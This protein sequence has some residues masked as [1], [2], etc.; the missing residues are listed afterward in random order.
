[1]A[2]RSQN[3]SQ[4]DDPFD[5]H[6]LPP[7]YREEYRQAIDALVEEDLEGYYEFLQ[8][9]DVVDFLCQPEV[10]HI[11]S[12][13]QVPIQTTQP[14]LAYLEAEADGSSDTYWPVHSDLDAPA[15]ELGWPPQH[16]CFGPTE[17]TMLVNPSDRNMPSIKEQARRLICS[18]QQVIAVVMDM[19]TDVDLFADL[20][21]A[22]MRNVA[23]YILLDEQNA[24]Y[25]T[26]MV[27]NCKVNLERIH[28]MRV[29]TVS[30]TTYLCRTGKSFKGQMMDRFLLVDCKAVLSGN[31]SFMWSFE[32]I[33]RCVAHLFLGELVTTFDEEF[34]ILYAQSQAL[35]I[36]NALVPLLEESCY[37]K[38]RTPSFRN[39]IGYQ[40]M[41]SSS[42]AGYLGHP[43]GDRIDKDYNMLPFRRV[44]P[45][46]CPVEPA[47]MYNNRHSSK[48]IRMEQSFMEQGRSMMTS[49]KMERA[50]KRHSYAEGS[51]D[52]YASSQQLMKN[53]VMNNLEEMEALSTYSYK[54]QHNYQGV[55]PGSGHAI[56]EKIKHHGYSWT[57]HQYFD[58]G[59]PLEQ[60]PPGSY[61][62]I[63]DC[64]SSSSSKDIIHDSENVMTS[65]ERDYSDVNPKRMSLG[66]PYICQT[67]PTQLHPPDQRP[68]FTESCLDRQPQDPGMKQGLRRWRINSYLSAFEDAT[69]EALPVP[70]GPDAFE[71]PS[72]SE[73]KLYSP[74][75][76]ATRFNTEDFSRITTFKQD[77][78]PHDGKPKPPEMQKDLSGDQTSVATD[79]KVTPTASES[80]TTTESDKAEE[81]ELREPR[82]ISITKQESFRSRVSPMFQR[83]SRLRSSLI[84][85]S[86]NL[87]QNSSLVTKFTSGLDHKENRDEEENDPLKPS[88]AVAQILEKRRCTIR[89]PFDWR[90]HKRPAV[91]EIKESKESTE[92]SKESTE[93]STTDK[94]PKESVHGKEQTKLAEP[95]KIAPEK[96]PMITAP[97]EPFLSTTPFLNMNDPE[98]RLLYFKELAAKRK[99]SKM[100]MDSIVRGPD[101]SENTPDTNLKTPGISA[102]LTDSN[103]KLTGTSIVGKESAA[104]NPIKTAINRPS[105]SIAPAEPVSNKPEVPT[106]PELLNQTP[107][108]KKK[109]SESD[110]EGQDSQ[111]SA[112]VPKT[113]K[114]EPKK[115]VLKPHKGSHSHVSCD[116]ELHSDATD[117][118]KQ[119]IKKA[120]NHCASSMTLSEQ[121]KSLQ[122]NPCLT[123]TDS[124]VEGKQ[125]AKAMEFVKKHPQKLQGLLGI[126]GDMEVVALVAADK[127]GAPTISSVP[128]VSEKESCTVSQ[129]HTEA[130]Q[131]IQSVTKNSKEE[132][133][134]QRPLSSPALKA[135]QSRYQTNVIYS[136]NLRDDTKVM[137]EQISASSQNRMELAKKASVGSTDEAK[138]GEA[139]GSVHMEDTPSLP[140]H[141]R[142]RIMHAQ[143]N[144]QERENLLK[145]IENMRKENKVYSRFE[146]GS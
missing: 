41:E 50:H 39:P 134:D 49:R 61:S 102:I 18:A 131:A 100:A 8:S 13:V 10:E 98:I 33:H 60:E 32:K 88:T 110:R 101:L 1:M 14:E 117:T 3:S 78:I 30:G 47:E 79:S 25:F 126:K 31:Y 11:K 56:N 145:K 103:L 12:T 81:T 83:S 27:T 73:A 141:G 94:T 87:E 48:H 119:E 106:A 62:R 127:A 57:D 115:D 53:R 65:G 128:E 124:S 77:L 118:E 146:M 20:L 116:K 36:E 85:S 130:R 142:T 16:N 54:E 125:D 104:E 90:I 40:P 109:T 111:P 51:H 133:A 42:Y 80:S 37:S 120:R 92:E 122:N 24:H 6:Y 9:A 4:G 21:D 72:S 64:L 113:T 112:D 19:F 15:L 105:I 43:F 84:F 99:A 17:V 89:E 97:I 5:P 96:Q 144:P 107:A 123:V 44:D 129:S 140:H 7:H 75:P 67:S 46:H 86:C 28:L 95:L 82:E 26:A 76:S 34:R 52:S 23:V 63:V 22:T 91:N 93:E 132:K 59:Y 66:Q 136:S 45:F 114:S 68:L 58:T 55:G 35:V 2:H 135:A 29:R 139:D 71:L 143:S 108:G 138:V 137:L 70:L 121:G 69:E 38:H 74:G